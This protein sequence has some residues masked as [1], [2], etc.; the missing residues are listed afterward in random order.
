MASPRLCRCGARL[1]PEGTCVFNCPPP[2]PTKAPRAGS[3][4]HEGVKPGPAGLLSAREAKAG[5]RKAVPTWD[6]HSQ[7]SFDAAKKRWGK[8]D[9]NGR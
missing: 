9:V 3:R 1:K 4:S 8:K 2:S 5:V 6:A 7:K